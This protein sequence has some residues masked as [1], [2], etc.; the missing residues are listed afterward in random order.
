[1]PIRYC[2]LRTGEDIC[3]IY[4]ASLDGVHQN[5]K[6]IENKQEMSHLKGSFIRFTANA[7]KNTC[8]IHD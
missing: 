3:L 5:E 7:A 6:E 1:M 8:I 2:V 4:F